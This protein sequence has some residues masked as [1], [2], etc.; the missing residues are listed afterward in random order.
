M[1]EQTKEKNESYYIRYHIIPEMWQWKSGK[2][3]SWTGY[4]LFTFLLVMHSVYA[5]EN[6]TKDDIYLI[7]FL[8]NV[9]LF[10]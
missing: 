4:E 10:I 1:L 3:F 6:Q 8:E 7:A 9:S 2:N 5:S